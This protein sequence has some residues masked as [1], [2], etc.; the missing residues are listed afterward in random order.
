MADDSVYLVI[1]LSRPDYV[2]QEG[3]KVLDSDDILLTRNGL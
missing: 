3:R 1:Y 2:A